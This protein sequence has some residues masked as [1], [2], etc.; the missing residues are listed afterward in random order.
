LEEKTSSHLHKETFRHP[1]NAPDDKSP[2][3]DKRPFSE[4]CFRE[5]FKTNFA[6]PLKLRIAKS[7]RPSLGKT[8]LDFQR[9]LPIF[10]GG[11]AFSRRPRTEDPTHSFRIVY[12][13]A[14]ESEGVP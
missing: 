13:T 14:R 8:A 10:Y 3:D 1:A 4:W 11:A 2:F 5:F 7:S 9:P 6:N 12:G